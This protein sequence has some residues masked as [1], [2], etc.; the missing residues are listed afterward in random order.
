MRAAIPHPTRVEQ[1]ARMALACDEPAPERLRW[2]LAAPTIIGASVLLWA[3]IIAPV[4]WW[5]A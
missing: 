4:V 1:A 3:A 5:L 2:W